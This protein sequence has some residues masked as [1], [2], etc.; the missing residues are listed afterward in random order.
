M[1]INELQL[2]G[3]R[4]PLKEVALR[5]S[6]DPYFLTLSKSIGFKSSTGTLF[7]KARTLPELYSGKFGKVPI[8]WRW[9]E[10]GGTICTAQNRYPSRY[11]RSMLE[12]RFLVASTSHDLPQLAVVKPGRIG[13]AA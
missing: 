5:I 7:G 13:L 6:V 3:N 11:R 4:V 9:E 12:L 1:E 2:S 8:S 10:G